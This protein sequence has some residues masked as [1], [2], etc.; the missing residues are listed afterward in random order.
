MW[1]PLLELHLVENKICSGYEK[2][3]QKAAFI[4]VIVQKKSYELIKSKTLPIYPESCVLSQ[5]E[6][7]VTRAV[8]L[9]MK[10]L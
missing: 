4:A 8:Q 6:Y 7:F 5:E 2:F 10:A 1:F 9:S 3:W